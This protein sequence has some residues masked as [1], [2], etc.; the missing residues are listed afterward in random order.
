MRT[1]T[2]VTDPLWIA[3]LHTASDT[4]ALPGRLG[5]TFAP[6]K[7]GHGSF[8][9]ARWERDL[10]LDLA[11]LVRERV[12]LLVP[13]IEDH[14][15]HELAIPDL[16]ARAAEHL[17]V[18]R[19]PIRD[20]AV[21]S[22]DAATRGLVNEIVSALRAGTNVVVHCRGGLG[23]AGTIGGLVLRT[24]GLDA[25][26]TFARLRRRHRTHCPEND[27][28]RA[29]VRRWV[30]D[31]VP[32]VP[33]P[34]T[35][36]VDDHVAGA[37]FGAAIG[38]AL[39]HPT[40]FLSTEAIRS[41]FGPRGVQ[42]Y[43]LYETDAAGRR[44]APFTDD[45][46]MSELVLEALLDVGTTDLDATMRD[47][48]RRFVVWRHTPRGGHRA[49]GNACLAGCA[50][51]ERGV[52]WSEAGGPRAGGCGSVMRAWPF[53]LLFDDLA[54]GERWA[55]A[56]SKLTHR[57]PIAL[58]ASAAITWGVGLARRGEP[59]DV[60]LD[61]MVGAAGRH[62]DTT[63][64]MIRRAIDEARDGTPPEV[65]LDRLRG[66]AAHEAIAGATYVFA[67]HPDAPRA[68][69]L[70]GA[71]TPGDSDSLAS[72]AGALVGARVGASKLPPEWIREIERR[73]DLSALVA[74]ASRGARVS[75]ASTES[76]ES[77]PRRLRRRN[78]SRR[79]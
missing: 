43:V 49:P 79:G 31:V 50:A 37:V 56:H 26:E 70:E 72:I 36:A 18:R 42:G 53:G 73:D 1:K 24:L 21:P 75:V 5:L 11:V 9:D 25:D 32:G 46:Q 34:S 8:V 22:D 2:S 60:I 78:G 10:D 51:L 35:D 15:L 29:Y 71:N 41:R 16:E 19:F 69:L 58:A 27:V 64:Q 57:H 28:Q 67:R 61:A 52:A 48:A 45:T 23:R 54:E 13:L 44:F 76:A 7:K 40:E 55:V 66:W 12:G 4:P 14:E 65:T 20:G 30:A 33:P 3:W 39:G 17:R 77:T 38:D 68:A 6:G 74:R 63:A 62:D 47:L 59:V